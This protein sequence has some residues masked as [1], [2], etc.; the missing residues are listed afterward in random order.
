MLFRLWAG[1]GTTTPAGLAGEL[2]NLLAAEFPGRAVHGAG[3]AACHG[4]P[5]L[6]NGTA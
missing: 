5:L 2:L 4:K 1:N 3:D 6:V